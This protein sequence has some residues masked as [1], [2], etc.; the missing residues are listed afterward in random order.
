MQMQSSKPKLHVELSHLEVIAIRGEVFDR[1]EVL[2]K[3]SVE[4]WSLED[5]CYCPTSSKKA[6][7]RVALTTQQECWVVDRNDSNR[8][9][10]RFKAGGVI[11]LD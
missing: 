10:F 2:Q 11:D 3:S 4:A 7:Q 8:V 6:A 9:T 5:I 1:G